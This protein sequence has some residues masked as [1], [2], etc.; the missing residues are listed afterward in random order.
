MVALIHSNGAIDRQ[1]V[2]AEVER[3]LA[4]MVKDWRAKEYGD[5]F[6]AAQSV[7]YRDVLTGWIETDAR[8]QRRPYVEA[9]IPVVT[10]DEERARLAELRALR[11][12]QPITQEGNRAYKAIGADIIRIE[13]AIQARAV[14][15]IDAE[16]QA[17]RPQTID[18]VEMTR[19]ILFNNA[20]E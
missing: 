20:A 10:T 16:A 8:V 18:L 9:L 2:S 11:D 14:A 15:K 3:Q 13:M 17:A 4:E 7:H 19:R 5:D 6:I 1:A 12:Q